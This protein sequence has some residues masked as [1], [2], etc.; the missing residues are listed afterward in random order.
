MVRAEEHALEVGPHLGAGHE[1]TGAEKATWAMRKKATIV[2]KLFTEDSFK[3][4]SPHYRPL[5][6]DY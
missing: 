3:I 4:W 2:T 5:R 1:V 6:S